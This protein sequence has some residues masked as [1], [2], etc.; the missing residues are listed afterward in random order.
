MVS[1]GAATGGIGTK[2]ALILYQV[3]NCIPWTTLNTLFYYLALKDSSILASSATS[4]ITYNGTGLNAP[5]KHTTTKK[6][7]SPIKKKPA[8]RYIYSD[9]RR[10]DL[11]L[12]Y[13]DEPWS[14][15]LRS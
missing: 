3:A 2:G 12:N 10:W 6:G 5:H 11:R 15:K 7:T 1:S 14:V 13:I 8:A 4:K 9:G